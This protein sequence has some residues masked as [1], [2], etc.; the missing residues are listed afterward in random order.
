MIYKT[1][2]Y[3]CILVFIGT[4]CSTK[5]AEK[6]NGSES[7]T[8]EV[9]EKPTEVRVRPLEYQDF[10]YE[11]IANGTIAAMNKADMKF[12]ANEKI[13]KIYVRNG[14]RVAK[15]QKIAELDRFKLENSLRQAEE[16]LEK[17]KLD[18]QDL[19]IGQGYSM[20]DSTTIPAEIMK[21]AKLRSSYDQSISNLTMAKYNLEQSVLYAPFGGVVA[22]LTSK[23]HNY[24]VG[25]A[26]CTIIDSNQPEVVFNILENEVPLINKNNKVVVTPFSSSEYK[27]E[28]LISEINPVVD[29][30]GLVR[31]KAT[32][33]NRD[34][35]FFE[36]MNVKVRVQRL[37]GKQLVIPKSALVLRTNR[38][39]VFTLN[40]GR[41]KWVYVK[42]THENSDS[43][44]LEDDGKLVVGDTIIYDGTINL[45]H[46]APVIVRNR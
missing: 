32:V 26:F 44:A 3:F 12:Q 24:P 13:I 31:V 10:N 2:I 27:T 25:D 33:N 21:I 35:K 5:D 23:E 37:L 42:S 14:D 41:A 11:L 34:G 43:Y 22:N 15:G 16:N 4:A 38:E 39:V 45:A 29:K 28:G 6:E 18:L 40:N 36:G 46:E 7:L 19:L 1:I 9:I 8:K 30:N 20:R 17:A